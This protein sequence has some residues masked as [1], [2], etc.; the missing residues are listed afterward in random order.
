VLTTGAV[1][2]LLKYWLVFKIHWQNLLTYPISFIFWRLRQFL[3]TLTSLTFWSVIFLGTNAVLGYSR[4]EM[5]SYIFLTAFLQSIILSTFLN[6]LAEDI[7]SGNISNSFVRPVKLFWIWI[8][9]EIADKSTNI[10]FVIMEA[11]ILL[12]LFKPHINFPALPE[13]LLFLVAT[14]LGAVVLFYIMLLFGSIGFW[15]QETW[16]IRFLFYMFID[17]TAGKLFPLNI[18]PSFIQRI[19]FLTPFPYLSYVQTQLF[20]GKYD[21]SQVV[22]LFAV[23]GAWV[24]G[25]A[26]L[27]HV[28]W[29]RGLKSY[30]AAGR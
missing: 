29:N 17:V 30:G 16:G 7:Y 24:I 12:F 28:V 3:S 4:D 6:G 5:I 20:L 15:S 14:F 26:T 2:P 22:S 19:L 8:T 11:A 21:H 25:L 23:L 1:S 13:F 18:L 10:F 9:Q 27:F